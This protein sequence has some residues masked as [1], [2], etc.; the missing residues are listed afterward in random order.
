M[1]LRIRRDDR[2]LTKRVERAAISLRVVEREPRRAA[3][4]RVT[5]LTL[6][7]FSEGAHEQLA[8]AIRTARAR[9]AR[10][11]VLDLR[12]NGG[13][14]VKEAQR[15][16]S[17]FLERGEIVTTRGRAVAD[18]TLSAIGEA[19]AGDLPV[20]VLVDGDTASAAEIVA[21]ALQD[22]ERARVAGTTTFGKGVFQTVLPL[23]NGGAL[24]LTVGRYF[25]PAG[26]NLAGDGIVPDV[27]AVDDRGTQRD[28]A[29]GVALDVL[30]RTIDRRA[31]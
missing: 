23:A 25:T 4:E 22:H 17:E 21:G 15:V 30:G 2:T 12:G 7:T 19:A 5:H 8:D 9:G 24:N 29:L 28:E 20:V 18:R 26:R 11:I 31:S 6:S 27:R 3:G 14:L 16:A 13:G 1:R 10:G